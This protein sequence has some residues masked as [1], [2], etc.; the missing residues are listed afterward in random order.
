MMISFFLSKE[1]ICQFIP[2][3][4]LIQYS[5]VLNANRMQQVALEVHVDDRPSDNKENTRTQTSCCG[6]I[7]REVKASYVDEYICSLK[8]GLVLIQGKLKIYQMYFSFKSSL[9]PRTFFGFTDIR[10]PKWDII[11]MVPGKHISLMMTVVT[12]HGNIEFTSFYTD[13]VDKFM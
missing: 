1:D 7:R 9:N 13:P 8:D 12:T 3:E 2:N 11:E 10:V 6:L 5:K 4:H